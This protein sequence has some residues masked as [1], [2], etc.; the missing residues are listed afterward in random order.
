MQDNGLLVLTL[1]PH[2]VIQIGE[3]NVWVKW[4]ESGHNGLRLAIY[5]PK[6]KEIKRL[7]IESSEFLGSKNETRK[8]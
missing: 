5:G 4:R 8:V 6:D 7:K 1:K 2:E 3:M